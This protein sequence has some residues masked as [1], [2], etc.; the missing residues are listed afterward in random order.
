MKKA[1]TKADKP[2][3]TAWDILCDPPVLEKLKKEE[4]FW[5]IIALSRAVNALSF[6]HWSVL[7][8]WEDHTLQGLRT[9]NNLFLYTCAALSEG[10]R[11]IDKMFVNFNA[12]PTFTDLKAIPKTKTAKRLRNMHLERARNHVA[13]HFLPES[14][15]KMVNI[16]GE[17]TC[18]FI[19]G[20]GNDRVHT[21]YSFADVLAIE[22]FV[23]RAAYNSE[24]FYKDLEQLMI[25]T[26]QLAADFV[27]A[28][29]N[30]IKHTLAV[31]G[32]QMRKR[33]ISKELAAAK[34]KVAKKVKAAG[35]G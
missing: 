23:G 26:R 15:G 18:S 34:R 14:F 11:L 7:P 33:P 8:F 4:K 21:Y 19:S 2:E 13:F 9:R 16:P 27:N 20:L 17:S 32:F 31:W 24:E 10:L 3:N 30:L 28:A 22:F 29:E 1:S 25:G 5:Q 35:I 6:A 12:E